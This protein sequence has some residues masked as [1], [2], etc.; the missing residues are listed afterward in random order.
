MFRWLI[1]VAILVQNG[2]WGS[3]SGSKWDKAMRKTMYG[4]R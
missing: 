1:G 4:I 3:Y 2:I